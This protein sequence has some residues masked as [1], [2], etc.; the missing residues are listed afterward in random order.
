MSFI[1]YK[2]FLFFC[3]NNLI[4]FYG[5]LKILIYKFVRNRNNR[6][7]NKFD[8]EKQKNFNSEFHRTVFLCASGCDLCP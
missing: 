5:I 7:V 1:F 2:N 6:S 3:S 4:N 8:C